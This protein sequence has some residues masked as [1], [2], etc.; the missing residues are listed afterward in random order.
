MELRKNTDNPKTSKKILK[1]QEYY[2]SFTE[3]FLFNELSVDDM[4][5]IKGRLS[6]ALADA[7]IGSLKWKCISYETD[8]LSRRIALKE[9]LNGLEKLLNKNDFSVDDYI[10]RICEILEKISDDKTGS[11]LAEKALCT[12]QNIISQKQK[13]IDADTTEIID[14]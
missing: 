12:T 4:S 8:T 9:L 3:T 1:N 14:N 7:D 6:K 13:E 11:H 5:E 10:D 2:Q